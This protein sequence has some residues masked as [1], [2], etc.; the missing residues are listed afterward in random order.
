MLI[1]LWQLTFLELFFSCFLFLDIAMYV[2]RLRGGIFLFLLLIPLIVIALFDALD[3]HFSVFCV[4]GQVLTEQEAY[5]EVVDRG[6]F[7]GREVLVFVNKLPVDHFAERTLQHHVEPD[8]CS[9]S[10]A[11]HERVADVHLHVLLD[12]V[13]EGVFRH[14]FDS[15]EGGL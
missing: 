2:Y 3:N 11:L 6:A 9:A 4:F 1:V 8:A 15:G 13:F 7:H 5:F 12:D 10:V 14:L